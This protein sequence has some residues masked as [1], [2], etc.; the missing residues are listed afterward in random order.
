MGFLFSFLCRVFFWFGDFVLV[1][2]CVGFMCFFCVSR[3]VVC[4]VFLDRR[5]FVYGGVWS[6]VG[7][8]GGLR[9]FFNCF[10]VKEKYWGVLLGF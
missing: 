6:Y 9:G 10:L 3:S 7:S 1:L 8:G 2:V 5:G 4:L